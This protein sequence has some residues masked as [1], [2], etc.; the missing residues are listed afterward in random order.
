MPSV[1]PERLREN[2]HGWLQTAS[3]D[4]IVVVL[5]AV[6][7]VLI[8]RRLPAATLIAQAETMLRRQGAGAR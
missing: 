2:A 7:D 3:V 5:S 8:E 6:Q 4:E 1:D